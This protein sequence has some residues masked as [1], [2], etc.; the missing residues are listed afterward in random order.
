MW[1][2]FNVL[3]TVSVT[4]I[5]ALCNQYT[6]DKKGF[7]LYRRYKSKWFY[8][9]RVS[10]CFSQ[11]LLNISHD[12]HLLM[13][14]QGV[15]Y[16]LGCGGTLNIWVKKVSDHDETCSGKDNANV[17]IT[18]GAT[19]IRVLCTRSL[20]WSSLRRS[21]VIQCDATWRKKKNINN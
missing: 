14:T 20:Q 3:E 16:P 10:E 2:W 18:F 9:M 13:S 19:Q 6:D 7:V 21:T 4:F 15:L 11:H 12:G 17:K 5:R 8:L 1:I